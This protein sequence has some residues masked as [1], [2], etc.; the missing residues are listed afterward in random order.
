MF[1]SEVYNTTFKTHGGHF[2]FYF[3]WELL[4][5]SYELLAR[6]MKWPK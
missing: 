4:L 3:G 6:P 2:E 1:A 5:S